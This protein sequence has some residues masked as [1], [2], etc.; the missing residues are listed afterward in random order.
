MFRK[1]L[2][3]ALIALIGAGT[4]LSRVPLDGPHREIATAQRILGEQAGAQ[5]ALRFRAPRPVNLRT[6]E[7]ERGQRV[8]IG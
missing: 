2:V 7:V 8:A 5:R 1:T 3:T 4:I 6:A